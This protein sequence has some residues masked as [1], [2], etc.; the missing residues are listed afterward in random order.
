MFYSAFLYNV[1]KRCKTKFYGKPF[2]IVNFE[3]ATEPFGV[4]RRC[5]KGENMFPGMAQD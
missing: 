3:N 5:F 4:N 1:W 2:Q